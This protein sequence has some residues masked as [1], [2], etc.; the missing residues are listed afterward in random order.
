MVREE[1]SEERCHDLG[2]NALARAQKRALTSFGGHAQLSH[3][4]A[5]RVFVS[6]PRGWPRRVL[7]RSPPSVQRTENMLTLDVL[8]H[9]PC[10]RIPASGHVM[11][12]RVPGVASRIGRH[13]LE[14]S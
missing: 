2:R 10:T 13:R 12:L 9:L 14:L 7:Q 4:G 5:R 3:S 8:K 6:F 1:L 11:L